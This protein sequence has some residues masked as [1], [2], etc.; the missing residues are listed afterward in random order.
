MSYCWAVSSW[1]GNSVFVSCQCPAGIL[2]LTQWLSLT[3][4]GTRCPALM[5]VNLVG[6][7]L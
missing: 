4:L 5:Q 1:D 3:L 2:I 6:V 7:T